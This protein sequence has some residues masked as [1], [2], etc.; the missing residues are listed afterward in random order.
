MQENTNS[1]VRDAVL[2]AGGIALVAF[3]A[4]L[5]LA[6]PAVRQTLLG[7]VA[8]LAALGGGGGGIGG[9]GGVLPD[10]ERYLKLKAM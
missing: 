6:H 2:L 1:E 3:G 8:P 7:R 10:V 5:I 4:G 9:L